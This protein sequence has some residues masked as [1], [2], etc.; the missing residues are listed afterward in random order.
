MSDG[1][2]YRRDMGTLG[3]A[4]LV[5]N[6][7]IGA[8][9]FGLPEVLHQAVGTFAPWLLLIGGLLVMSIVICF[10]E[11]TKLTDRSGGP[12]RFVGDAWGAYPGFVIGWT[13]Y[14]AR[15]ISFGANVLVLIAY[16]AALW[17]AIGEGAAKT[18]AIVA[19]FSFLAII[20]VIGVRRAVSALGAMTVV[21]LLPLVLLVIVGIAAASAPGPVVLPQFGAV[22]GIALGALYAFVGFENA[23]VPAGETRN[24]KRAMPRALLFSLALVTLI[25]FG[26]QWAYSH[27]VIA[28]SGPE[29]PIT[30]LARLHWGDV[31]ALLIAATIV[32]SVLANLTAGYTS[33]SRMPSALADDGLLPAWFGKVS[34]WGTPANSILFLFV[35]ITLFALVDDFLVLAIMSTVARL[36]AYIASIVSLPRLRARAG[37]AVVNTTIAIAAPIAL[38]LSIWAATQTTPDQWLTLGGFAAVGS[39]LYFFA[40]RTGI[41][42]L[43]STD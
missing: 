18:V 28:G 8:G 7:L 11:L 29:A 30:E 13:Y 36:V 24:P 23:T 9:I 25:Y 37:L 32:V 21:K 33:T 31:G 41:D 15:V 14:A 42:D 6:G 5:V 17:P 22:E 4:F 1:G 27:S 34:R 35:L 10:A 3:V 16:A 26:L 20:N 19:I 43:S 39:L 12:Q 2:K 40:R 38:L